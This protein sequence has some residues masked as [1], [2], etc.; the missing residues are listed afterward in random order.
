MQIQRPQSRQPIPEHAELKFKGVLFDTYQWQQ[1]MYD[2][3]VRTF[4]KIK[5]A[6]CAVVIAI[7]KDKKILMSCQE[8][9]G[10]PK[11]YGFFGGLMEEGENPL[12]AA[13][14][15]LLE[16]SG[17]TSD[18]CELWMATQPS[19]KIDSAWYDFVFRDCVNIADQRLDG[20][21][22]IEV[23]E[24]DFEEFLEIVLRDDFFEIEVKI[25]VMKMVIEGKSDELKR[26]LLRGDQ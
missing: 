19:S 14:R 13:K 20:G 25:H 3:S 1:D 23:L 16:E 17:Y 12:E 9:P 15:E 21:E 7:T 22:K 4:E 6:D 2:S 5:R 26:F 18:K 8:Q 11:F 24:V 10:K